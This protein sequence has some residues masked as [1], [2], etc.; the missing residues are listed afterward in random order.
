METYRTHGKLPIRAR[1][2][3]DAAIGIIC[4][5]ACVVPAEGQCSLSGVMDCLQEI[6]P[7]FSQ[8]HVVDQ[9][10]GIAQNVPPACTSVELT[11]IARSRLN[12]ED[13]EKF[14]R[15]FRSFFFFN[16]HEVIY[17]NS[18]KDAQ[19]LT[20]PTQFNRRGEYPFDGYFAARQALAQKVPNLMSVHRAL[21]SAA[22]IKPEHVLQMQIPGRPPVIPTNSEGTAENQ[23]GSFRSGCVFFRMDPQSYNSGHNGEAELTSFSGESLKRDVAFPVT[24][25]EAVSANKYL[26]YR[27][28]PLTPESSVGLGRIEFPCVDSLGA[29]AR[30]LRTLGPTLSSPL[31]DKLLKLERSFRG[32]GEKV[33]PE[34]VQKDLSAELVG[35]ELTRVRNLLGPMDAK[36]DRTRIIDAVADFSHNMIGIHPFIN[37]NGRLTRL[38]AET[39]LEEKGINPPVYFNFGEDVLVTPKTFRAVFQD[40]VRLSDQLVA[41]ACAQFRGADSLNVGAVLGL[42]QIKVGFQ[43]YFDWVKDKKVGLTV[44][45]RRIVVDDSAR[46]LVAGLVS[47]FGEHAKNPRTNLTALKTALTET[48]ADPQETA[49]ARE[50]R[51]IQVLSK[52]FRAVRK[53]FSW[54][55]VP[56]IAEYVRKGQIAD[57][58]LQTTDNVATQNFAGFGLYADASPAGSSDYGNPGTGLMVVDVPENERVV[59]LKDAQ[60]LGRLHSNGIFERDVRYLNVGH[61]VK[62]HSTGEED[63]NWFVYKR[64]LPPAQFHEASAKDFKREELTRLRAQMKTPHALAVVDRLIRSAKEDYDEDLRRNSAPKALF[65]TPFGECYAKELG[66]ILAKDISICERTLGSSLV[67][68]ADAKKCLKI[69]PENVVYGTTEREECP[70]EGIKTAL[71][72]ERAYEYVLNP[73]TKRTPE[74]TEI[75]ERDNLE[76]VYADSRKTQ[77]KGYNIIAKNQYLTPFKKTFETSES[78]LDYLKTVPYPLNLERFAERIIRNQNYFLSNLNQVIAH[79]NAQPGDRRLFSYRASSSG[80]GND[81]GILRQKI[82]NALFKTLPNSPA[83]AGNFYPP[84]G[85]QDRMIDVALKDES[86]L[87]TLIRCLEHSLPGFVPELQRD[88]QSGLWR[89][90]QI[91]GTGRYAGSTLLRGFQDG[92]PILIRVRYQWQLPAAYQP[93]GKTLAQS[94]REEE[95]AQI[96]AKN[97]MQNLVLPTL[98]TKIEENQRR[99]VKDNFQAVLEELPT[100]RSARDTDALIAHYRQS[101]LN[102]ERVETL[103][104]SQYAQL[105]D[106]RQILN[107]QMS[108]LDKQTG[109]KAAIRRQLLQRQI[110][111]LSSSID[112]L[113]EQELA[114]GTFDQVNQHL[115]RQTELERIRHGIAPIQTQSS[116]ASKSAQASVGSGV[117]LSEDDALRQMKRNKQSALEKLSKSATDRTKNYFKRR[118]LQQE[119]DQLGS[120]L[121]AYEDN[122]D[123]AP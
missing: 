104:K 56:T 122:L 120:Q 51:L 44:D 49:L 98:S 28:D 114:K 72:S 40:A 95:A 64:E 115:N 17:S 74:D 48:L 42:P 96:R 5:L 82:K 55:A 94:A 84:T 103:Q 79:M 59:D 67:Y 41:G 66:R 38:L 121:K 61:P 88:P 35:S 90:L 113:Y 71:R 75:L 3:R 10:K 46:K 81:P 77:I 97:L 87:K 39:I 25:S 105:L 34:A 37:G 12:A 99:R 45:P 19:E 7:V 1:G 16:P 53:L 58:L 54:Q 62:Y 24:M 92:I 85:I 60:V 11:S 70:Q 4:S 117:P 32:S 106:Q 83:Q 36:K 119:I 73:Q 63:Q 112:T 30:I 107:Q 76:V 57:R 21:L 118:Q 101:S 110:N 43:Q 65:W 93:S 89:P 6:L 50:I 108:D 116:R 22:S 18:L 100:N 80:L 86:D 9:A 2:W 109:I 69:T 14:E 26:R 31:R 27:D 111:S 52:P 102:Q 23:L 29:V 91:E 78:A 68:D 47:A 13:F 33:E 20:E 123:T 15:L 8:S